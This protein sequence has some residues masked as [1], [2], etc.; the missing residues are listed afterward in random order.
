MNYRILLVHLDDH[1]R[2]ATRLGA[3][4]RI[5]KQFEGHL[6]GLSTTGRLPFLLAVGTASQGSQT[7]E[8][9]MTHLR[10][11]ADQR[12][13]RFRTLCA[14]A[15]MKTVETVVDEDDSAASVV[16][17]SHCSDL[18]V[19]GQADPSLLSY[20]LDQSMVEQVVLYGA[21]PTLV[22]P[23][24]GRF[25]SVGDTVLIAWDDSREAARAVT[26]AMPLLCKARVVHLVQYKTSHNGADLTT[27]RNLDAVKQ[28][29]TW[30][31]VD[32]QVRM[33]GTEMDVGNTLL[34][35]AAD[36][37]VDLIVMG[38][39]GH[40]RWAERVL[41]GTTRTLLA[42]MTVPTLMSH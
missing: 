3:A 42:S 27:H 36:L 11:L 1:E 9:A 24:A 2:C 28:W 37:G 18:V 20:G 39:Y 16:R 15:G 10:D 12:A 26:D 41:G 4:L 17:H 8:L 32:A 14:D 7:L 25:D 29:L 22:M 31:G 34:S 38:A 40:S 19:I 23:Y 33:E 21:R 13:Q 35:L 30:H 5:A 6:V